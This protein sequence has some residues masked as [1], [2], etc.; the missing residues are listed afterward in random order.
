MRACVHRCLVDS[1][2][3]GS[4]SAFL[5]RKR[6]DQLR[7]TIRTLFPSPRDSGLQVNPILPPSPVRVFEGNENGPS[8]IAL[9]STEVRDQEVQ[10]GLWLL[11]Q[12]LG[13]LRSSVTDG[14]L[15]VHIDNSVRNLLSIN[16]VLHSLGF[17]E[18]VPAAGGGGP[19][20][21]EETWRV[22]TGAELLQVY[23]NF[24]RGK[25]HLLLSGAQAC[26]QEV[27]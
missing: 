5:P 27:S 23:V 12:A 8:C 22:S 9:V 11:H 7:F 17:Q 15:Q 21:G 2:A 13:L 16:A 3:P 24:L 20:G 4:P 18:Y 14:T 10:S 26:Q 1:L 19:D 25:V 6:D